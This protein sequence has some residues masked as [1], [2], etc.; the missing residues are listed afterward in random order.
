MSSTFGNRIKVT[1]FGESH[2]KGIGCVIDGLPAGKMIDFEALKVFMSRRSA[3][4]K[5]ETHRAE[6]DEYE[7]ISGFF[8]GHTT[9]SPL[10]AVTYNKNQDP[11]A[12]SDVRVCPRPSQSDYAASVRY[13]G[14]NDFRGGG[15]LSGRLTSPLCFAGGIL[16]Q[17][18]EGIGI[19]VN[20]YVTDEKLKEKAEAA[21]EKG[22]SVG[23]IVRC[24]IKG[25]P[26]GI[27]D[28]IFDGVENLISCAVFGI[29]GVKGI[30]FGSGFD[31][32]KETGSRQNDAFCIKDGRIS[33]LTNN[34]GG[35]N[36]GITNGNDIIFSAAFKPVPSIA[37][38][39]QTVDMS[40]MTEKT[41]T[42]GGRHDSC[43]VFRA[44]PCVEAAAAMAISQFDTIYSRL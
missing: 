7:I 29:P 4:E 34:S 23:G 38:P 35:I 16:K 32:C 21:K 20:A 5:Y 37:L 12:Y 2:G 26:A 30:E 28:P 19:T 33:T 1:I 15:H 13:G 6:A 14:Y 25:V 40:T 11:S 3:A 31:G 44:L 22:D 10:C 36:G 9:G 41:V 8:E 17:F 42:V 39:Q 24:E 18:L 43:F 27:G